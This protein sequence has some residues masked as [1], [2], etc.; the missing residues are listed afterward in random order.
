V[1]TALGVN[2]GSAGAPVVNGGTLTG[3]T[4]GGTTTLADGVTTLG[5]TGGVTTV[6]LSSNGNNLVKTVNAN[7][8]GSVVSGFSAGNGTNNL[9]IYML[10]TGYTPTGIYAA[11]AS[12][13]Q[14]AATL[15]ISSNG[16]LAFV[17]NGGTAA[18]MSLA[19]TGVLTLNTANYNSCTALTTS[20]G[21]INCTASDARV[22]N[23]LGTI[24]PEDGLAEVLSL[25]DPHRYTFKA[26][27]GPSGV[28]TGNFAQEI[29]ASGHGELVDVGRKTDL[30]PAGILQY[31]QG[32]QIAYLI[33]AVK[34]LAG[35]KLSVAGNCWWR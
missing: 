22:K 35:C 14:A 7:A 27:F 28:H 15:G 8:G 5:T 24:T 31:N 33:A 23:D 17:A 29:Q 2:V 34:A 9:G 25:H 21:V 11:N 30:T 26:G 18:Q 10:G 3:G 1:A 16:T 32:E 20:S 13:I 6:T 4:L 12:I 19:S